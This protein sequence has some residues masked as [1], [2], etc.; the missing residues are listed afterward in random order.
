MWDLGAGLIE[1]DKHDLGYFSYRGRHNHRYHGVAS[2]NHDSPFHHWQAGAFLV[3]S[4]LLLTLG[5]MANDAK[6]IMDE[7]NLGNEML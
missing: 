5:N 2:P 6:A 7:E 4:S 1:D 3:L